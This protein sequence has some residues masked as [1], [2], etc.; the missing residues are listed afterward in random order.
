ML[1]DIDA[2]LVLEFLMNTQRFCHVSLTNVGVELDNSM[3]KY[4][5]FNSFRGTNL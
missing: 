1:T 2:I 4:T 3:M 5:K